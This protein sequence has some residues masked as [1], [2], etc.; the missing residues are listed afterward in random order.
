MSPIPAALNTDCTSL[1]LNYLN[2]LTLKAF[3]LTSHAAVVPVRKQIVRRLYFANSKAAI[4]GFTFVW[5]HDLLPDVRAI[6]F[7]IIDGAW[8]P[9]FFNLA[10]DFVSSAPALNDISVTGFGALFNTHPRIIDVL[11]AKTLVR[12][13][14][15]FRDLSSEAL[16]ALCGIRGLHSMA[17]NVQELR[18]AGDSAKHIATIISNNAE[19]LRE[20][21]IT[22]SAFGMNLRLDHDV[23]PCQLVSRLALHRLAI[24]PEEVSR[25]FPNIQQ[26]NLWEVRILT[27]GENHDPT[28]FAIP[29]PAHVPFP[30]SWFNDFD[31]LRSLVVKSTL[32]SFH[33]KDLTALLR[34]SC[35]RDLSLPSVGGDNRWYGSSN[36]GPL[37]SDIISNASGLQRLDLFFDFNIP[38]DP[39]FLIP[40]PTFR[41]S[42]TSELTH[43]SLSIQFSAVEDDENENE[44]ENKNKND[45]FLAI[46]KPWFQSL[47]TLVHMRL[48]MEFIE[49][50]WERRWA[51]SSTSGGKHRIV[52]PYDKCGDYQPNPG[53]EDADAIF[54]AKDSDACSLTAWC[55]DNDAGKRWASELIYGMAR[56]QRVT[57]FFQAKT[58]FVPSPTAYPDN[59]GVNSDTDT[60][61]M[62]LIPAL[63]AD[64][65]SIILDY[66]DNSALSAF[67][68]TS[69]AAV[70]PVRKELARCLYFT[71]VESAITDAASTPKI[72]SLL[73]SIVISVESMSFATDLF[74]AAGRTAVITGGGTGIGYWMA[75]A[76]VKNGGKVYITGRREEVLRQ[77]TQKLD[78]IS[79][80]SANYF[81]ADIA[82]QEGI[83]RLAN[84]I[85]SRETSIDVLVNNA[86]TDHFD[87]QGPGA[88]L[89]SFD[90]A[91]WSRLFTTNTWSPA[92]VTSA[93]A[94]LLVEAAKKGEGRGSVILVIS[95]AESMWFALNPMTGYSVSK[96]AESTL[97][98]ILANKFI[99]HGV[100]VNAISPG[101]FPTAMN[102]PSNA[103]KPSAMPEKLVP[104]KRNG[105]ADDIAGA[106]L[107]LATKAS[108]YVTGQKL[109]DLAGIGTMSLLPHLNVDC[110]S[111]IL[112]FLEP[113]NLASV[114]LTSHAAVAL[115]RPR[116]V[117]NLHF[118]NPETAIAGL[119][120]IFNHSLEHSVRTIVVDIETY[121]P[122]SMISLIADLLLRAPNLTHF[123]VPRYK[124]LLKIEPCIAHNLINHTHALT[125]L[126]LHGV[127][128]P[129]L[130]AIWGIRGLK[131]VAFCVPW[132]GYNEHSIVAIIAD[133]SETLEDITLSGENRI[134]TVLQFG[135]ETPSCP[136]VSRLILQHLE[137]DQDELGRIFPNVTQLQLWATTFVM[138]SEAGETEMTLRP[139]ITWCNSTFALLRSLTIHV[140]D[141]P[142]NP[143][144]LAPASHQYRLRDL[145]LLVCIIPQSGLYD[146]SAPETPVQP[147][148]IYS[149]IVSA[150]RDLER[151]ELSLIFDGPFD[152]I[153][154]IPRWDPK[155]S[156]T[157]TLTFVSLSFDFVRLDK[158]TP[159][160]GEFT[161]I[162]KQW[163][164][165]IPSLSCMRLAIHS[166][167]TLWKRYSIASSSGVQQ[168]LIVPYHKHGGYHILDDITEDL[169]EHAMISPEDDDS[170]S[171]TAWCD[172]SR[173]H[174]KC[175]QKYVE[176]VRSLDLQAFAI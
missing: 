116:I 76:W 8:S 34:R 44:N 164:Q 7:D 135:P 16:H 104:M 5:D 78:A 97:I 139:S 123:V 43:L 106:F 166:V 124:G 77:A 22:G 100:R 176:Y 137:V 88:I 42:E 53:P 95:I 12:S 161:E 108:A 155:L 144:D 69:H 25:I 41:A 75:E 30:V 96:A 11:A 91:G 92:A 120:S 23:P 172:D 49:T 112:D 122:P 134:S 167:E 119:T 133:N 39:T 18:P 10:V 150:A 24:R 157:S 63:D 48:A 29:E 103:M 2:I 66:L 149:D 13:H 9:T 159:G 59:P 152:P 136:L 99:A 37:L 62:S 156:G 73:T 165:S 101:T 168:S 57:D 173:Q 35:L 171:L 175:T 86:G 46:V 126:H 58:S 102:D 28:A 105:N 110:T 143:V 56:S 72:L 36:S 147:L 87:L 109:E 162:V 148:Q 83:D 107:F 154:L 70:I 146:F 140:L 98:K 68:L 33:M 151:L 40:H 117:R 89:P 125:H 55:D 45:L 142:L 80:N 111:L 138:L 26:Q 79:P 170:C 84:E 17:L 85:A 67:A 20:V 141:P 121:L 27:L 113:S 118:G 169:E 153:L 38:Y 65:T 61:I 132:S 130:K 160:T 64:C 74:N 14:L 115:I 81:T 128:S 163:F 127:W 94:P 21:S 4:A 71:D 93:L 129:D 19:T 145:S 60:R 158:A 82:T 50:R 3:A 131:S 174:S 47:P 51:N 90:S 31:S 32:L 1:I 54:S 52:V 114:S 6:V 15:S